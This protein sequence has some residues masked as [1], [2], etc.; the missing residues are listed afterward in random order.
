MDD[1]NRKMA[2]M[3]LDFLISENVDARLTADWF[4]QDDASGSLKFIRETFPDIPALRSPVR[5]GFAT[6]PRDLA[7]RFDPA[8]EMEGWSVSTEL[9]WFVNDMISLKSLTSFRNFEGSFTQDLGISAIVADLSTTGTGNTFQRRDLSSDQWTTEL[10]AT[11]S[12]SWLDGVVGFF[13]F[14]E[15]QSP[16]NTVGL[17]PNFGSPGNL[18]AFTNRLTFLGP[19]PPPG[20]GVLPNLTPLEAHATCNTLKL[21]EDLQEIPEPKRVCI[22]SQLNSDAWA[23]FGQAT[24]QLGEFV[25]ALETVRLKLGGRYT[26]ETVDS[27][28]AAN[29]ILGLGAG[30]VMR[31]TAEQTFIKRTFEEF[32]PEVG[33][34]WQAM[35]NMMLYYTYSEGFKAGS[36]EN[37]AGSRTILEPETIKNH[38]FGLKSS[39]LDGRIQANMSGFFYDLT[40]LQVNRTFP[41]PSVG[42]RIV[43]E[44]AAEMSAHG[45]E[46]DL[47]A[48]IT[49][50]F[51]VNG[52]VA[53]LDSTFSDFVSANPIDPRNN[54]NYENFNPTELDLAGNRTRNSPK[55]AG[56]FSAQ[57]DLFVGT[58]PYDGT[59]TL[60]GSVSYRGETFFTEFNDDIQSEDKFATLDASIRYES[61]DGKISAEF[62]GKN[63]T[64]QL[65]KSA[66]FDLA[67]AEVIGANYHPPRT[68]GFSIG[69]HF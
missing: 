52:A 65:R 1:L 23:I 6:K 38:E 44:N 64:D 68:F 63:L 31:F 8:T 66:T 53:Y 55:W 4:R 30:P 20:G 69:Y 56:N 7:G 67:T 3:H 61:G 46:L 51:R 21:V 32:T 28:N 54:P 17:E 41:D 43:F 12:T 19:P 59:M 24:V 16:T 27:T 50:R 26:R 25:D 5:G 2:R 47:S 37:N 33:L 36:P 29:I 22:D 13:Y 39:W 34:E 18:D 9:N 45:V 49:P 10:Q 42:F 11:V 58:L 14:N 40:N 57:Y 15:Q 62:W 35:P 60:V 48:H